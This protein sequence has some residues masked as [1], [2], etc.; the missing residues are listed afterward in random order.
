V[1]PESS[2][3][4]NCKWSICV[5]FTKKD[6]NMVADLKTEREQIA[7]KV[8]LIEDA[9][10]LEEIQ[11]LIDMSLETEGEEG[12]LDQYNAEIDQAVLDMKNGLGTSHEALKRERKNW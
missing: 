6:T 4:E 10:I 2:R 3:K 9:R 5:I 1:D 8:L 7:K 11:F 12:S